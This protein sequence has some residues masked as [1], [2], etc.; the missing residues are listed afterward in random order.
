MLHPKFLKWMKHNRWGWWQTV[1]TS[2]KKLIIHSVTLEKSRG[3][4]WKCVFYAVPLKTVSKYI[5][6]CA[7]TC[8]VWRPDGWQHKLLFHLQQNFAWLYNFPFLA[9]PSVQSKIR[10]QR[11]WKCITWNA[12]LDPCTIY[13][14]GT[15]CSVDC[16]EKSFY[17]NDW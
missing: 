10:R 2:A 3:K 6:G 15:V 17:V 9:E 11:C 13:V 7:T 5:T 8:V 1:W 16:L 4:T 12:Q 14:D